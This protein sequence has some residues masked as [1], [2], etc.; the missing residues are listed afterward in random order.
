MSNEIW[1]KIYSAETFRLPDYD[2]WLDQYWDVWK[3]AR[4]IIDL[5]CGSG[6][7][8]IFLNSQGVRTIACDFSGRALDR[9][10][11]ILP[12]ARTLCFDMAE[13]LPFGDSFSDLI[14]ADLSLHY[15][16][17]EKTADILN[18]IHR[19]LSKNG[20]LLCRVNSVKE[21]EENEDKA[22]CSEIE[23]HVY[24]NPRMVK[25]FFDRADIDEI[26]IGWDI[27]YASE[28]IIGKYGGTKY[29]W[30]ICLKKQ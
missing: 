24:K 10:L 6:V 7:N 11:S 2:G 25:R 18:D 29:A 26:F 15:F 23:R 30:E 9:L 8:T 14:I 1:D 21:Y 4:N 19:V 13:G 27:K 20:C 22:E 28:V 17:K 3:N 12:G 16:T 5:G